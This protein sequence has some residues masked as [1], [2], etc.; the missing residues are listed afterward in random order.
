MLT[1]IIVAAGSSRRF[2]FDKLTA[3]IAGKPLIAHT[4]EAF[5]RTQSVVD[6]VIVTQADR[7]KEFKAIVGAGKVAAIVPGGEHRHD[8]VEAG[9]RNLNESTRYVAVHD[10]ARPLITPA[11]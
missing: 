6:I 4:V 10:G 9:L 11:A 2:G 1:A 8:S 3:P 7:I 5:E